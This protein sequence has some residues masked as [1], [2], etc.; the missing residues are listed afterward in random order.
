MNSQDDELQAAAIEDNGQPNEE[1][2]SMTGCFEHHP[3]DSRVTPTDV[4]PTLGVYG[5]ALEGKDMLITKS[6]ETVCFQQNQRDEVRLIGE[7][8]AIAGS[9]NA[10]SGMK[11]TNYIAEQTKD[12]S[13]NVPKLP[14]L[15]VRRL[16]PVEAERLFGLPDG[17]TIPCF[18]P[19]DIT[20]ELVDRFI[21][22]FFIW[23]C[24][25]RSTKKKDSKPSDTEAMEDDRTEPE[26]TDEVADESEIEQLAD[27]QGV[28]PVDA[29]S[30]EYEFA[31]DGDVEQAMALPKRRSRKWIRAWL[32]KVSNPET[33]PDAPRYKATGN[34]FGV[35]C[36]R[37]IGLGIQAMEDSMA[38]QQTK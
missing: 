18:K 34:S 25:C 14:K 29:E 16:M 27:G 31:D 24:F 33:C 22:I 11:N 30:E 32:A 37:W 21:E 1:N 17:H 3:Q 10:E 38:Q 20:D 5:N 19:E 7:D 12:E 4:A 36:I 8:G 13:K 26:P 6:K 9:L 35:N 2:T 15:T 28:S 23:D